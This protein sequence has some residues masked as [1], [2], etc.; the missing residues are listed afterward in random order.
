MAIVLGLVVGVIV[1]GML[2]LQGLILMMVVG[3]IGFAIGNLAGFGWGIFGAVLGGL[4][5]LSGTAQN[6]SK[7]DSAE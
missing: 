6:K 4:I 7:S 3:G 1:F 5:G 2:G